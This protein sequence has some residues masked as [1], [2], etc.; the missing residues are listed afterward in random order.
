M[1]AHAPRA[2]MFGRAFRRSGAAPFVAIAVG[3]LSGHYIF[4]EPLRRASAE[5][6]AAS[7]REGGGA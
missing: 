5:V 2:R 7:R 4:N 3:I 1:S 6:T